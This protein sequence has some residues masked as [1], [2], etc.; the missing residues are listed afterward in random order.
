MN[1]AR[2]RLASLLVLG[3]VAAAALSAALGGLAERVDGR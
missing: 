2:R 1:G 3:A